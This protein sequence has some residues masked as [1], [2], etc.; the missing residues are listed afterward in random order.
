[1]PVPNQTVTKAICHV[2]IRLPKSSRNSP[3][4]HFHLIWPPFCQRWAVTTIAPPISFHFPVSSAMDI[5]NNDRFPPSLGLH[6]WTNF[7][8]VFR[9]A[10]D[11]HSTCTLHYCLLWRCHYHHHHGLSIE[12]HHIELEALDWNAWNRIAWIRSASTGWWT[13]LVEFLEAVFGVGLERGLLAWLC[14]LF[15]LLL[16]T[17]IWSL[18]SL[19]LR[20][21]R[22]FGAW[23][24][25]LFVWYQVSGFLYGMFL[26]YCYCDPWKGLPPSFFPSIC[27]TPSW[28]P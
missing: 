6:L 4:G 12:H 9:I 26:C 2:P 10:P 13:E 16:L 20:H 27:S 28:N 15:L 19:R 3:G 1:M 17:R 25:C 8:W 23:F 24:I 18:G 7:R 5:T 21:Q 11:S 22:S 14:L